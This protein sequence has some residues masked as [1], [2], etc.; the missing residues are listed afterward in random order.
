[1]AA[2]RI[3]EARETRLRLTMRVVE[4]AR[5]NHGRLGELS[6]GPDGR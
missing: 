6:E 5:Q 4:G 3:A 1:L 2:A